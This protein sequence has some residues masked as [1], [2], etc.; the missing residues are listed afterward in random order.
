MWFWGPSWRPGLL[1]KSDSQAELESTVPLSLKGSH[2]DNT[3]C[4]VLES[5]ASRFS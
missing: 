5:P 3:G 4:A 2:G 1:R